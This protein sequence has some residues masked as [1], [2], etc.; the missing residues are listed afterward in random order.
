M[1]RFAAVLKQASEHLEVPEPSRSRI[2]LEIAADL[3][4]SYEHHLARGCDPD[5]AARR[6]EQAFAVS[7]EALKHLA[8]IHETGW[9][10]LAAR[11]G[12]QVAKPWEKALL[13]VMLFLVLWL[14]GRAVVEARSMS[15]ISPFV[16]PLAGLALAGFV[17]VVWKLRQILARAVSDVR[18]LRSGL[19]LLL[20]ISG[21]S[22]AVSVW[23]LVF[24]LRQFAIITAEGAPRSVFGAYAGWAYGISYMMML[25]FLTAVF[26]ALL[27]FILM[28]M[29]ARSESREMERLLALGG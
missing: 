20:F 29:V 23:G 14:V 4:D 27:W 9:S 6:A 17:L 8:R 12:G 1:S 18:R 28:H 7:D 10:G 11:I 3:E 16:W 2:L 24:H 15:P 13:I 5:E 22:L 19:G 21:S 25:G 26:S